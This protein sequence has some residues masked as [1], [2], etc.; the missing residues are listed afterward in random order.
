VPA[1]EE[2]ADEEPSSVSS[3]VVPDGIG[4]I[5]ISSNPDGAEIFVD[6][7]FHGNTPATLKIPTGKHACGAEADLS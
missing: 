4:T 3:P 2:S 1:T 6:E 7:K 5:I